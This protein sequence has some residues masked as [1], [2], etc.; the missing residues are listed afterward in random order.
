MEIRLQIII[1]LIVAIG[2]IYIVSLIRRNR[3]ELKYALSWLIGSV[4]VLILDCF[5]NGMGLLAETL[6]IAM[7]VN[8]MFFFGFLFILVIILTLTVAVSIA[9]SSVKRLTQKIAL[10]EKRIENLEKERERKQ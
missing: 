6:G 5:P 7:P 10:L 1:A 9:A 3:L 8:M 2:I 4:L